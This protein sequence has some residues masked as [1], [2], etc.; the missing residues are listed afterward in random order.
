[1]TIVDT[2]HDAHYGS[3]ARLGWRCAAHQRGGAR[4]GGAGRGRDPARR[5]RLQRLHGRG[6]RL[7]LAALDPRWRACA[8]APPCTSA[9]ATGSRPT[10]TGSRRSAA[11]GAS[12][13]RPSPCSPR[14]RDRRRVPGVRRLARAAS[15][16]IGLLGDKD[17]LLGAVD[18]ASRRASRRRRRWP[19]SIREG[20]RARP[21]ERLF[22]APTAAWS[23]SPARSRG[24]LHALA[25]GRRPG[26]Q[27]ARVRPRVGTR[28]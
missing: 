2:I 1:M 8:A 13:S 3:R 17:I 23:R 15:S 20:D 19:P 21:A 11:S 26:P 12:T 5:A 16:L 18:V 14:S 4:A 24:K 6:A 25:A 7:G 10:P 28:P 22:P 9:T 27:G